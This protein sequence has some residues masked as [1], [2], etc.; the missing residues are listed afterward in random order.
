MAIEY[1]LVENKLTATEGIFRAMVQ[2]KGTIVLDEIIERIRSAEL[3]TRD[4]ALIT[5]LAMAVKLLANQIQQ[6]QKA[7]KEFQRETGDV[8][9]I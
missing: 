9:G 7:I 4:D 5:P 3:L 2:P 1:S 6:A 8:G